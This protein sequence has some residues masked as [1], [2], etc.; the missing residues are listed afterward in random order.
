MVMP[1]M[2]AGRGIVLCGT[3]EGD[4][5]LELS[6]KSGHI[7]GEEHGDQHDHDHD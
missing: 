6:H 2:A 5:A 4:F 7:H 3:E 1:A